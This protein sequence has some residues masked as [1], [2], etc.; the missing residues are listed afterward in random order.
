LVGQGRH[1]ACGGLHGER[2]AL[3]DAARRGSVVAGATA[4]V[5]LAPCTKHGRTPPCT[6]AL[7]A[8][9]VARVV[10]GVADPNQEN[11]GDIL[12]AAGIRYE[13]A[14]P[15]SWF[16][17]ACRQVHAGFLQRI[18]HGRPR[19]TAKWAQTLE[20]YVARPVGGGAISC[21][22]ARAASRRQRRRFDAIMVGAETLRVDNPT[23][24][25]CPDDRSPQPIVLTQSGRLPEDAKLLQHQPWVI[26][27]ATTVLPP[28]WQQNNTIRLERITAADILAALGQ[29]GCNE[30]LLEGGPYLQKT[31]LQAGLVDRLQLDIQENGQIG[32]VSWAGGVQSPI[33]YAELTMG[34]EPLTRPLYFEKT[35]FERWGRLA[36]K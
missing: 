21:P 11:A 17:A 31:F 15:A 30:L 24:R 20:D 22:V 32:D 10:V 13:V 36:S 14:S 16:G 18:L 8:A 9:G 7:I 4:Y 1:E 5:T 34:F 28:R 33:P 27:T 3:A 35:R 2:Q 25:S 23:L 12:G 19:V 29:A 6:D 26:C